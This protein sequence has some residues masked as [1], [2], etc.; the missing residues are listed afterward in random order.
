PIVKHELSAGLHPL[1]AR[2]IRSGH[3]C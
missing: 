2:P 1:S 3:S